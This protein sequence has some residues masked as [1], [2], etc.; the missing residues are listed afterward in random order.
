MFG[1][2]HPL[3]RAPPRGSG[4]GRGPMSGRPRTVGPRTPE[5][6]SGPMTRTLSTRAQSSRNLR[7]VAPAPVRAGH[8]T[9]RRLRPRTDRAGPTIALA[10]HDDTRPRQHVLA[11]P[12]RRHAGPRGTGDGV[13]GRG[14]AA[15]PPRRHQGTE[16]ELASSETARRRFEREAALCSALD[17]PHIQS[18]Y[19]VGETD[20]LY[21]IVLQYVEGPTLKQFMAGRPLETLSALSLAIQLADALAVAHASGIAHR[22]LK[23][24]TSSSGPAA[25]RG[26]S[27]SASPRCS[28]PRRR[29]GGR[30]V[31]DGRPADRDRS[32]LRIDGLQSPEQASGQAAD[33][34]RTCSASASC[35]TR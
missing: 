22:D 18:V 24:A 32:A 21:Y 33:H 30:F 4:R 6:P 16:A 25:R 15:E 5:R 27:T 9:E 20:G 14:P 23:P 31:E 17:N 11:L 19:D 1:W 12:D 29:A 2:A 26:S 28:C 10:R 7:P 13:Q 35:S 34:R 8:A 3:P